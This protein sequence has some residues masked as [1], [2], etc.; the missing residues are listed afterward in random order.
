MKKL[1]LSILCLSAAA[2]AQ[3]YGSIFG[4]CEA[5]NRTVTTSGLTSTTLVQGSFP[6]CT[7][8]VYNTGFGTLATIYSNNGGTALSN[9][10]TATSSGYWQF[11]AGNGTY[12]VTLSGTQPT[13]TYGAQTIFSLFRYQPHG[14]EAFGENVVAPLGGV[15][16]LQA[17]SGGGTVSFQ[18]AGTFSSNPLWTLPTRDANG[19]WTSNGSGQVGFF[20]C[21]PGGSVGAADSVQ[22]NTGGFG[23]DSNFTWNPTGQVLTVNGTSLQTIK[24][25]PN[26]ASA[27]SGGYIDFP[28]ITYGTTPC[29]DAYGDQVNIPKPLSGTF[30]TNDLILWN[31]ASPFPGVAPAGC[32]TAIPQ[33][34]DYGLNTNGYVFAQAGFATNN[35]SFNSIYSFN[36]GIIGQSI[37]AGGFYPPGTVTNCC[38][39]LGAFTYL[40]G[41][42]AMG[43]S[44]G[45]PAA[46]TI[47]TTNNPLTANDGIEQGT[48]Y[49]DDALNAPRV[50]AAASA[51]A[52]ASWV[53]LG[54]GGGGG[55]PG[56]GRY[57]IQSNNPLG[58]F[59]GDVDFEYIPGSP[60]AQVSLAGVFN[61]NG[62]TGGFDAG[63]ATAYNSF[64]APAGGMFALSFTGVNY[65]QVGTYGGTVTAGP[66]LTTSDSFHAGAISWNTAASG[67]SNCLSV[68]NGSAWGCIVAVAGAGG[69]NT[70]VQ[71]NSSGSLAG[72][73]SFIWNNGSQLLTVTAASSSVAGI[74]VANGFVKADEGFL[75]NGSTCTVYNCI[76]APAGGVYA[77]AV[78]TGGSGGAGGYVQT[79]NGTATP[80]VISGDS[81]HAGALYYNS[82]S[83]CE[84]V[85]SGSAW[86]C[87]ASGSSSP[88]G[89]NTNVQFNN[90]SAFGGSGNFTWSNGGQVLGITGVAATAGIVVHNAWIQADGGLISTTCVNYNCIATESGSTL[91]G[92]M[93]A[94]SFTAQNY[95]Q[96][97]NYSGTTSSGPTITTADTAHAGAMSYSTLA[98]CEVVYNG[99]SW[100]CIGGGTNYWT[101]S[102]SN[103]YNNSGSQV[104]IAE[105][106]HLTSA[107]LEVNGTI[108]GLN[109]IDSYIAGSSYGAIAFQT[110]AALT[111]GCGSANCFQVDFYGDI[112]AGGS[113]NAIGNTTLSL[114]PYRVGGTGVIDASRNAY[115]AAGT[116]SS[117]ITANGGIV[118]GAG[119]NSTI[120]IGAG[121]L[122]THPIAGA[123]TGVSCSGISDGY[124]ATTTDDYLV[125]CLGGSRFRATLA[126][127]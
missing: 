7:V 104:L 102:G 111:G 122:Y 71:Y 53:N 41:Y 97:G 11:F 22:Y 113:V 108:T 106:G 57:S 95:V 84:E 67:G 61:A 63:S 29:L 77:L 64:Q 46:G 54:G 16:T 78:I 124:I 39:T 43:H 112:S 48:F 6:A 115:F 91:T 73:A 42:M 31:S 10:F 68:Y 114:Y 103:L 4:F 89:S 32:A 27:A 2:F 110:A 47:A 35:N 118:S 44:V 116:F 40:G 66:A 88:G 33:N 30:G 20:S 70:Q 69:S 21:F 3:P 51:G 87:L 109:T 9:P 38:G 90:S 81:F 101:L 107:T 119:T 83:S 14:L 23:G 65:V 58:V 93:A 98:A 52:C 49:W 18:A 79:G 5:G 37:T 25:T 123:S 36:G 125:V 74:A 100:G 50:C 72:S 8:T 96:T 120:I 56:G 80:T 28:P 92:G 75:A 34:I 12:D 105:T 121:A 76:Q 99:S 127:Y 24:I 126:A 117:A 26:G 45:P 59:Y 85:Y 13:V 55:S 86:S 60:T 1:L 94:L 17:G 19:C 82:T 62:T 15:L